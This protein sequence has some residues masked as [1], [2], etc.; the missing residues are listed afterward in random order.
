MSQPTPSKTSAD[1]SASDRAARAPRVDEEERS[2]AAQPS[3]REPVAGPI[4]STE[5]HRRICETAYELYAQRGYADGYD[6]EDWLRAEV[7]V[8]QSLLDSRAP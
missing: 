3:V 7:L 2:P 1:T 8:D 5:R 6:V 4:D